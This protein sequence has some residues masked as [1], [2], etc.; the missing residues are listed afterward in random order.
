MVNISVYYHNYQFWLLNLNDSNCRLDYD[1]T[2][3][4]KVIGNNDL[5]WFHY[6]LYICTYYIQYLLYYTLFQA[7]QILS[8]KNYNFISSLLSTVY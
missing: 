1:N 4:K 6:I 5:M 3:I 7:S 8:Q 2:I